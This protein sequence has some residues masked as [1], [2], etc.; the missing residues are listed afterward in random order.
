VAYRDSARFYTIEG[1]TYP[2]VTTFLGVI[3]KSGPLMGWRSRRSAATSRRRS[4]RSL[5]GPVP[6]TPNSS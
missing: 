2:S 4:S 6:V 1:Q 5:P 3:D